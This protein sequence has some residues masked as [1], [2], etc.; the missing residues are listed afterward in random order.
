MQLSLFLK[1]D[2]ASIADFLYSQAIAAT[3]LMAEHVDDEDNWQQPVRSRLRS[4]SRAIAAAQAA[5]AQLISLLRGRPHAATVVLTAPA[6]LHSRTSAS[7]A[8]L[9]QALPDELHAIAACGYFGATA[10]TWMLDFD[11]ASSEDLDH[12]YNADLRTAKR[13]AQ[14]LPAQKHVT[15]LRLGGGGDDV[16]TVDAFRSLAQATQIFTVTVSRLSA[17]EDF[18][19]EWLD[20]LSALTGLQSLTLK[21]VDFADQVLIDLDSVLGTL[22]KL[23]LLVLHTG[24]PD[25]YVE[26]AH[27]LPVLRTI[28]DL[29]A[30]ETLGL[31]F[32]LQTYDLAAALRAT[33]TRLAALGRL[34]SLDLARTGVLSERNVAAVGIAACTTLT[35]LNLHG[36]ELCVTEDPALCS[37]HAPLQQLSLRYNV[38]LDALGA[39]ALLSVPGCSGLT[40]LVLKS[41][42][43]AQPKGGWPW[44]QLCKLTALHELD[45]SSNEFGDDGAAALAPRITSL[46]QLQCLDIA[47]CCM[48]CA[49]PLVR[50]VCSLPRLQQLAC[51]QR[52]CETE[53]IAG[54]VAALAPH[55]QVRVD[56]SW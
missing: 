17:L 26:E 55:L 24:G 29:A 51:R 44:E 19:P 30:L 38:D 49:G 23:T 56:R 4:R 2:A 45:L 47:E 25:Y 11:Y 7:L 36:C 8:H 16:V 48:T 18:E 43:I 20:E 28:A 22:T 15:A 54:V 34:R 12:L 31:H 1:V 32:D 9:Y 46:V 50:A 42:G 10:T 27:L 39:G 35:A 33:L 40:K 41:T 6:A 37:M 21:E 5:N 13:T 53:S 52:G 14:L 3:L